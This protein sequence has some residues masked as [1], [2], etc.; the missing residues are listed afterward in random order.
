MSTLHE[1]GGTG[2]AA[3]EEL[4]RA[5]L[6]GAGA[7]RL[8]RVPDRETAAEAAPGILRVTSPAPRG[9]WREL[10]EADGDALVTQSPQWADALC[11]GGSYRDAS[12]LYET[13]RGTRLLVPLVRRSGPWPKQLAPQAS[14]PAAWG[15]GGLLAERPPGPDEVEAVLADLA[16]STALRTSIRPNPLHA[17]S[18]VAAERLGALEIPRLAHVVECVSAADA[19]DGLRSSARRA[20]KKAERSGLEVQCDTSG[21]LLPAFHQLFRQSLDRWARGQNE[22]LAL[23]RWRG[24]RRDPLAKFERLA[25]HLGAA[26]QVWVASKDGVPAAS[27]IVLRGGNAHYTRG[28]MDPEI[29]GPTRA[30]DLLQWLAIESACEAGCRNYHMGE[31]GSSRSLD[32]FKSKFGARPVPY[33]EYRFERLPITRADSIARGAVKRALR[34]QDA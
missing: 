12:R 18:W 15:F 19:W 26:M 14:M 6:D 24:L 10:M 21:C 31:S 11:A 9:A 33:A 4:P 20:V 27:I 3:L 22:P 30:N 1:A 34:F 2:A 5:A 32:Q 29:A 25:E 7:K 8:G 17:G 28:A 23:A 16:S 13:R